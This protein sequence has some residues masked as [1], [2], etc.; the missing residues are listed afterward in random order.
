M[1]LLLRLY[2]VK[3][4]IE[5]I[6]GERGID[7]SGGQK[8]LIAFARIFAHNPDIFILDEAIANIEIST[9]TSQI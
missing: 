4:G 8:Q 9:K 6:I 2:Q 1:N 3:N 5:T 7:L